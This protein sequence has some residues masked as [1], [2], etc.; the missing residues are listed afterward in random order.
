MSMNPS[1]NDYLDAIKSSHEVRPIPAYDVKGNLITPTEY[2]E[3]IA[4]ATAHVCFAIV[5]FLIRQKHVY[6]AVV[7][8]I[9]IMRPPTTIATTT[10]KNVLHPKKND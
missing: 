9:T 8:D 4:G 2:E 10:L 3:K 7:R 1:N 5:H 6:N